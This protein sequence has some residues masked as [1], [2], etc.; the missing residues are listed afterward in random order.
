VERVEVLV[1]DLFIVLVEVDHPVSSLPRHLSAS[2]SART[3]DLSAQ[4]VTL[5]PGVCAERFRVGGFEWAAAAGG[6]A[7]TSFGHREGEWCTNLV[8]SGC[9]IVFVKQHAESISSTHSSLA[10]LLDR[11][12][13]N[14]ADRLESAQPCHGQERESSVAAVAKSNPRDR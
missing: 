1:I 4:L 8:P 12:S 11:R 2:L 7:D 3:S 6:T 10:L 5:A 14:R 13:E 9:C